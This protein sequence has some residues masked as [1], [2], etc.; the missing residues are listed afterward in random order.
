MASRTLEQR[1]DALE[2]R[3]SELEGQVG[4]L[5]PLV[6]QLHVDVLRFE[7]KTTERF[8]RL[9]GKVDRLEGKVDRLEGKVDGLEGRFDRLETFVVSLDQKVDALP[10][11]LAEMLDDRAK[12]TR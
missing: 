2:L 3:M 1:V 6:K 12:R 10:R 8:A 4:F 9:E 5:L 7:E 11:V